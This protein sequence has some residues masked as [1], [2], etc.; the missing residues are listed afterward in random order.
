M[1]RLKTMPSPEAAELLLFLA[2]REDFAS[3]EA[4][5]EG[6]VTAAEIRAL[7]R[8][9][10]GVLAQDAVAATA[11]TAQ[12]LQHR[13]VTKQTKEVLSLL[14]PS[15]ARRLLDSFGFDDEE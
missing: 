1:I 10:A 13:A 5:L 9:L 3:S 12:E 8:E 14:S 4:L 7:L 2:E 6:G 15:E 11:R